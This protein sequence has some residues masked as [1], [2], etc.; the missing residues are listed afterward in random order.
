MP[1]YLFRPIN[2]L[3]RG[4]RSSKQQKDNVAEKDDARVSSSSQEENL[5]PT[6][7][8][9]A[10]ASTTVSPPLDEAEDPAEQQNGKT[11]EQ[12][13][14]DVHEETDD[15]VATAA[16]RPRKKRRNELD[17]LAAWAVS[18]D[19]NNG[20]KSTRS[21]RSTGVSVMEKLPVTPSPSRKRRVANLKVEGMN[22]QE[23]NDA[24]NIDVPRKRA[25]SKKVVLKA[26]PGDAVVVN[27]PANRKRGRQKEVSASNSDVVEQLLPKKRR[28]RP[29]KSATTKAKLKTERIVRKMPRRNATKTQQESYVYFSED[30]S[31]GDNNDEE[32]FGK[33]LTPKKKAPRRGYTK[34]AGKRARK[35]AASDSSDEVEDVDSD[36]SSQDNGTYKSGPWSKKEK[37]SFLLGLKVCGRSWTDIAARFVPTR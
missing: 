11:S 32:D 18:A 22:Q 26:E 6:K 29:P 7:K 10:S 4:L 5:N 17:D 31:D 36:E 30:E 3:S 12:M 33:K 20:T 35:R 24:D 2:A 28:G 27:S 13:S 15:T 34:R 1:Q 14:E 19:G 16:R 37:L 8:K 25:A 9:D 23:G 21:S